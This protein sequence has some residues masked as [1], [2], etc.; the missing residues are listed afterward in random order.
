[1]QFV[2]CWIRQM[3][4]SGFVIVTGYL[5]YRGIDWAAHNLAGETWD[6][7]NSIAL[8]FL[9]FTALDAETMRRKINKQE[10]IK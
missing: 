1:M 8:A 5:E 4:F 2:A 7:R 6:F 3:G 9:I 10:E